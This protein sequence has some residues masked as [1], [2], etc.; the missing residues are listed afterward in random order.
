MASGWSLSHTGRD[1]ESNFETTSGSSHS[2]R[3]PIAAGPGPGG[4]P[5]T[6]GTDSM[7]LQGGHRRRDRASDSTVTMDSVPLSG[8]TQADLP[9]HCQLLEALGSKSS[10]L[11][12]RCRR[13]AE[14]E[15][16]A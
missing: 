7:N 10:P 5:V 4:P 8:L 9:E 16:H 13:R 3:R 6:V 2:A 1:S 14:S 15:S 12:E 11:A